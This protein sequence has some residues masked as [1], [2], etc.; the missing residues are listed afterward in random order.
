MLNWQ[1]KHKQ[2]QWSVRFNNRRFADLFVMCSIINCS[3][4]ASHLQTK[5]DMAFAGS[6]SDLILDCD[7]VLHIG[8]NWFFFK[9]SRSQAFIPL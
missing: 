5:L 7:L 6:R 2:E 4:L 8:W 1:Q 9:M 3:D